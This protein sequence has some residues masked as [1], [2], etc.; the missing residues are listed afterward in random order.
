MHVKRTAGIV[1]GGG[2]VAAW[3][4]GAATS[5]RAVPD[6]VLPL[7]TP[8]DARGADLAN[9]IARLRAR[10][11]PAATPH[12]PGRNPFAFR[13]AAFPRQ[14][15]PAQTRPPAFVDAGSAVHGD[16]PPLL[17]LSGIAED[18][19]PESDVDRTA[20]ISAA[21]QLFM[22]KEGQELMARYRVQKITAD[23]VELTDLT[24]NSTQRVVMK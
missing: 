10:L 15:N 3:L 4:A 22:V 11:R 24:D 2:A 16:A 20:F 9:E 13:A 1:L 21:G 6:P 18:V 23:A 7:S 17:K 12:A 19:T 5:N 8:V 14:E